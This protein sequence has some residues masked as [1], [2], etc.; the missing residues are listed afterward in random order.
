LTIAKLF[1]ATFA[2]LN[3][4]RTQSSGAIVGGKNAWQ[5]NLY[6]QHMLSAFV[7]DIFPINEEDVVKAEGW[8]FRFTIECKFYKEADNFTALFKNPQLISWWNQATAD[9]AKLQD[10]SPILIFKFN[11]TP[12]FAGVDPARNPF[13]P[14]ERQTV[15]LQYW[16]DG[17][18]RTIEMAPL[19]ELLKHPGW[20]KTPVNNGAPPPT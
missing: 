10:A 17:V 13:P 12:V 1:S 15:T 8:K 5:S 4:K 3:F 7:G 20:W 16:A 14:G 9:A 6:S 11:N 19:E 18:R 2:P